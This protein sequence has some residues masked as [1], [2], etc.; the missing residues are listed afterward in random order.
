M[1]TTPLTRA[2]ILQELATARTNLRSWQRQPVDSPY[3]RNR[4]HHCR[5]E[6]D[7]LLD[8]LNALGRAT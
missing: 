3:V 6:I 5:T 7:R 1:G 4:V 8:K 2:L